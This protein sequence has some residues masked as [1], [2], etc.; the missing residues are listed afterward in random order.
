MSL[1]EEADGGYGCL[2]YLAE[3]RLGGRGASPHAASVVR[4]AELEGYLSH[5]IL[6][7]QDVPGHVIAF[8]RWR[9]WEDADRV[10]ERYKDSE[11]IRL[12]T[13]SSPARETAG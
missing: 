11:T 5:Q 1:I 13:R 4:H 8:A 10:R 2:G 7:D 6:L 3:A 12:L 9:S